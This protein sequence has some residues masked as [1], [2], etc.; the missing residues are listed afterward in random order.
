MRA[1]GFESEWESVM[2]G[3][4]PHAALELPGV[5][6]GVGQNRAKARHGGRPTSARVAMAIRV[7]AHQAIEG[8][9][10]RGTIGE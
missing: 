5:E 10:E 9:V 2:P 7:E 4:Q 6:R 8:I 1:I 3:P